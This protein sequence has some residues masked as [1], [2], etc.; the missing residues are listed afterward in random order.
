MHTNGSSPVHDRIVIEMS[1]V[2]TPISHPTK[3]SET[4]NRP[5]VAF[6]QLGMAIGRP[7]LVSDRIGRT[8]VTSETLN[9]ISAT[10]HAKGP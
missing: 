5:V 8:H 7:K 4:K 10:D 2:P 9:R 3:L 6:L 1:I